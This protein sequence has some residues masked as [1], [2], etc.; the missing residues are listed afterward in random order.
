MDVSR[1]GTISMQY[2]RRKDLAKR[3]RETQVLLKGF[4]RTAELTRK[5]QEKR[6][7]TADKH[8]ER[9]EDM[10][11]RRCLET[12]AD[13]AAVCRGPS[14]FSQQA[15][16]GKRLDE[17]WLTLKFY[18]PKQKRARRA[19]TLYN[20]APAQNDAWKAV[21][22]KRSDRCIAP[23]GAKG[24]SCADCTGTGECCKAGFLRLMLSHPDLPPMR[25]P[26]HQPALE[27]VPDV[28]APGATPMPGAAPALAAA[29]RRPRRGR[30][31]ASPSISGLGSEGGGSAYEP[32]ADRDAGGEAQSR[33]T[34]QAQPCSDAP[35]R[36]QPR[37]R[38][39]KAKKFSSYAAMDESGL[40]SQSSQLLLSQE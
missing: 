13:V 18:Y 17:A 9:A 16:L 21:K 30:M 31:S 25:R 6:Q 35:L 26:V 19:E 36:A 29:P 32:L 15:T 39:A 34:Q 14:I 8:A 11:S 23:A 7:R 12:A 20:F 38:R 40:A 1:R 4:E 10:H 5:E 3:K 28:A 22:T 27:A 37:A 33:L 2:A 24:K